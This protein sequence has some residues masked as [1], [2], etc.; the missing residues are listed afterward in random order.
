MGD[1]PLHQS[2]F[3][4]SLSVV[5]V[6]RACSPWGSKLLTP[7]ITMICACI[8]LTGNDLIIFLFITAVIILFSHTDEFKSFQVLS[9]RAILFKGWSAALL[10]LPLRI[11]FSQLSLLRILVSFTFPF[12]CGS[13]VSFTWENKREKYVK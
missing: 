3:W 2:Y 4:K 13:S 7:E 12:T 11:E 1:F 5:N 6:M 9:Y 8:T 10:V